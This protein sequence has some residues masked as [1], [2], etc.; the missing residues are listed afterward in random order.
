MNNRQSNMKLFY[1]FYEKIFDKDYENEQQLM[2]GGKD[3]H[4]ILMTKNTIDFNEDF[5][6]VD[7]DDFIFK[8]SQLTEKISYEAALIAEKKEGDKAD[9][10]LGQ[11]KLFFSELLF[12]T[13]YI[14]DA[15]KIL[16]VGA[17]EG[18]HISKLADLFPD[19]K[20]DLWDPRKF[21]LQARKNIKLYDQYFTDNLA[22]MYAKD[23]D[24]ILFLC[25]IRTLKVAK[26]KKNKQYRKFDELIMDDMSMQENWVKIINPIYAYL[27]FR[28]P[29]FEEENFSYLPGT[30]YLQPYS[31]KSTEARLMTNDY[32]NYI[33]YN[34]KEHD[35][36]F[37]YFNFFYRFSYRYDRWTKIFNQYQLKNCWDNTYALY[38]VDY[39]LRK[40]H[41]IYSDTKVGELFM[42][43]LKFHTD[44]YGKKYDIVFNRETS[45]VQK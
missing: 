43:I 26:F 8:Y 45:E 44:K 12:L 23:N 25:D 31:P 28:L 29:W 41:N 22:Q 9:M 37:S 40:I 17:A 11:F 7:T 42:E 20:F 39:Y 27:K 6:N 15:T 19:I 3:K 13:K 36:K 2:I 1:D 35:E 16:Y 5:V 10:H 18:Y 34:S 21:D 30:I 38:I 33:T 4:D 32:T 14:K 24:K